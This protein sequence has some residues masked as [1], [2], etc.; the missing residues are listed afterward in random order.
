MRSV[1]YIILYTVVWLQIITVLKSLFHFIFKGKIPNNKKVQNIR[2][3][4]MQNCVYNL[5]SS[6]HVT[7]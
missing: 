5:V 1:R 2:K 6:V 3:Y 7:K 4:T